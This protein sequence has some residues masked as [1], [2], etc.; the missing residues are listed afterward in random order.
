MT[1]FLTPLSQCPGGT[2][3]LSDSGD[4]NF[5]QNG[6]KRQRGWF[7]SAIFFHSIFNEDK[8]IEQLPSDVETVPVGDVDGVLRNFDLNS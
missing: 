7:W 5:Y 1:N 3:S 4:E 8:I 6:E 2:F